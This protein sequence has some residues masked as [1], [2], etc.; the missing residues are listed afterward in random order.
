MGERRLRAVPVRGAGRRGRSRRRRSVSRWR[1]R[2]ARRTRPRSSAAAPTRTWSCTR[3]PTSGSATRWRS[4]AGRTSGS[5]RAS[6]ATPSGCGRRST[7]EGT[8]QELFEFAYASYPAD[9]RSGP[10]KPGD[11]GLPQHLRPAV[12]DR[13]AMA[14]HQLRLAMGDDA[15]F[16]I[17]A[18][19][20]AAH[21]Y[22]NGNTAQFNALAE[23]SPAKQ[24]DDAVQDVALHAVPSR[25][26]VSRASRSGLFRSS[27]SRGRGSARPRNCTATDRRA[28]SGVAGR[29][30]LPATAAG[31]W[32]ACTVMVVQA[33][34]WTRSPSA[35]GRAGPAVSWLGLVV[36]VRAVRG[37]QVRHQPHP[38][39]VQGQQRVA[40][41][42]A[43][44]ERLRGQ[45]HL[46]VGALGRAAPPDP[47]LR[48]RQRE[49][50][51]RA[52]RRELDA[53]RCRSRRST[54]CRR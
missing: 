47:D 43:R 29:Q 40:V 19:W 16:E 52:V 35:S 44:V 37:A 39:G 24:L 31:L 13:G 21:K 4:T 14:V 45:V 54:P 25:V 6:P 18:T 3:T 12:Y 27:R 26:T 41:R 1:T 11:P 22:G 48:R 9:S 53:R 23:R 15:F 28:E 36:E 20:T 34:T 49:R 32:G 5:T 33:P 38:V 50:P 17:V 7:G 8:A 30:C 51:L 46:R 2:P 42:D 10:S